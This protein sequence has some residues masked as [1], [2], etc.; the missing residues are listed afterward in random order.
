MRRSA[1]LAFGVETTDTR[2]KARQ[3][4]AA[5]RPR[6]DD[7]TLAGVRPR[8]VMASDTTTETEQGP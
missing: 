8:A 2:S 5:S 6:P 3:T 7:G 4:T 1:A